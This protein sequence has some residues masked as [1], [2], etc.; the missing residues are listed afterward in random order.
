M[1]EKKVLLLRPLHEGSIALK[2]LCE[3]LLPLFAKCV[4]ETREYTGGGGDFA[5]FRALM[6]VHKPQ[7]TATS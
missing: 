7:I 5:R 1:F 4:R 2:T 6:L 3:C